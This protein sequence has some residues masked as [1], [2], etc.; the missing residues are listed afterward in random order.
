MSETEPITKVVFRKWPD[1]GDVIALFP[2]VEEYRGA[3]GSY[4]TVGQHSAADYYHV[5]RKTVAATEAEYGPVKRELE[6]R[7]FGYRFRVLKRW[8]RP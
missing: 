3:C 2:E 5:I 1:T 4:M 7:P 6:S 8:V